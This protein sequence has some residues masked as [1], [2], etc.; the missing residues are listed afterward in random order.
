MHNRWRLLLVG[1]ALVSF[2]GEMAALF[3]WVWAAGGRGGSALLDRPLDVQADRMERTRRERADAVKPE[4]DQSEVVA[5]A[6]S[7]V[8][9]E[10]GKGFEDYELKSVLF[11]PA[12][13]EWTVAFDPKSAKRDQA[14]CL[15]VS[16]LDTTK[17]TQLRRCS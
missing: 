4:L 12:T 3:N 7:A 11:E 2:E 6:K 5:L 9:K 10:L 1:M 13:R 16:V 8:K 15:Y 17:T 14:S